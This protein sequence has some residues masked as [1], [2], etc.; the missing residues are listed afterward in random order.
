[1]TEVSFLSKC[2][3]KIIYDS[4]FQ[5]STRWL[6]LDLLSPIET[7][8]PCLLPA[9]VHTQLQW[10]VFVVATTVTRVTSVIVRTSRGCWPHHCL[11]CVW[12][13]S[14]IKPWRLLCFLRYLLCCLWWHLSSFDDA[15][16]GRWQQEHG[17]EDNVR[18]SLGGCQEEHSYLPI[19]VGDC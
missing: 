16:R 13:M 4:L 18:K 7:Q 19:S 2:R 6:P 10:R 15:R 8:E 5:L 12:N 9:L 14:G 3:F 17:R 1:M 11:S